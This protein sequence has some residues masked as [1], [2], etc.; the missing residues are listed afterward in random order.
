MPC[1]LFLPGSPLPLSDLFGGVCSV[2]PEAELSIDKLTRCCNP[3]HARHSCPQA[4]LSETDSVRFLVRSDDGVLI[5]VAWVTERNHYPIAV[6]SLRISR[7]LE[8]AAT[9]LEHQARAV[10]AAYLHQTGKL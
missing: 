4:A 10:A 5:D 2:D 3:G 1:P 8:P 9:T 6:G 7:C